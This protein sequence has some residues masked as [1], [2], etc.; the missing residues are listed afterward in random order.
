MGDR[1]AD[2]ALMPPP[3]EGRTSRGVGGGGGGGG[4]GEEQGRE[5][6]GHQ[7]N[8]RNLDSHVSQASAT[9]S[10]PL[11]S[12]QDG[13]HAHGVHLGIDQGGHGHVGHVGQHQESGQDS[14]A[15]SRAQSGP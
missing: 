10:S 8:Q 15:L 6:V 3:A 7:G 12:I 2:V 11:K 14:Q 9:A 5:V 1:R 4:G 13:G